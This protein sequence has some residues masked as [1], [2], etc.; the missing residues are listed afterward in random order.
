[1][2]LVS[3]HNYILKNSFH[4]LTKRTREIILGIEKFPSKFFAFHQT[5]GMQNNI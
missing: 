1:M 3:I 2:Y 4:K 5:H